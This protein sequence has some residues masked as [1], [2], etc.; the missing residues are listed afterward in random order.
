MRPS[1]VAQFEWHKIS[2]EIRDMAEKA[3]ERAVLGEDRIGVG[4][5]KSFVTPARKQIRVSVSISVA[6]EPF[7]SD[8]P[9]E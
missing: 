7:V 8:E 6:Q 4:C 9:A 5:S 2:T 3:I 1:Y